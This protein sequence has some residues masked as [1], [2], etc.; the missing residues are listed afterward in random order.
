MLNTEQA[1]AQEAKKKNQR[2]A[3]L[4]AK[5][6][7][8]LVPA[9]VRKQKRAAAYA[10]ANARANMVDGLFGFKIL[11]DELYNPQTGVSTKRPGADRDWFAFANGF[12]SSSRL[13][14]HVQLKESLAVTWGQKATVRV[15]DADAHGLNNPM[16]ALPTLWRAIQALHLGRE[17]LLP[18]L[19]NG[20]VPDGIL[21][22]G[23][24][25]TS[26]NGLHYIERT[27]TPVDG[28]CLDA[29]L[30]RIHECF[31]LYNVTI[32]PGM[33]EVLPSTNGQSRLP[34]GPGCE[35]VY[36]SE[37]AVSFQAGAVILGSLERVS[38]VFPD[39]V[40]ARTCLVPTSYEGEKVLCSESAQAVE[41]E[42][43]AAERGSYDVDEE[44]MQQAYEEY[45]AMPPSPVYSI[46]PAN[47]KFADAK[48]LHRQVSKSVSSPTNLVPTFYE[49]RKVLGSGETQTEF[50]ERMERL[51][52]DGAGAG[53]R[54][55]EFW[56]LCFYIRL[57]RG[58]TNEQTE[59]RILSWIEKAPHASADLSNLNTTK[60]KAAHRLLRGHIRRIEAGLASGKFFQAGDGADRARSSSK[61]G[62][63]L[64]LCVTSTEQ[65]YEFRQ[66]G[67]DFL[68][69]AF[70][71][72]L[73]VTMPEWVKDRLPVLV[74]AIAHYS[75]NGT[76]AL[77]TWTV[78][79]YAC[80][81]MSK[82]DP[83]DG[84]KRPAYKI[85]IN[86]LERF[87]VVSGIIRKANK[88]QRLAAVY[89]TN[90]VQHESAKDNGGD[91]TASQNDPDCRDQSDASKPDADLPGQDGAGDVRA[92]GES[93]PR[94]SGE[95]CR[96][97]VLGRGQRGR[98]WLSS[99]REAA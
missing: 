39:V 36:P 44:A 84:V 28:D 66:T 18:E 56:D 20:R 50:V 61:V 63:A 7:A 71:E 75:R 96:D 19:V 80:S 99:V 89:E 57:T 42:P 86:L 47:P 25:V 45:A 5:E 98:A 90:T 62:D 73:L 49:G 4:R 6:R 68:Q 87:G 78:K 85:L 24:I 58:Y 95:P 65:E 94:S 33:L 54:N 15:I 3:R 29:D 2:A 83:T 64:L 52:V 74:G 81:R 97:G 22:D 55:E 10:R 43:C 13:L 35:F 69:D 17:V 9:D 93:E 53:Q 46:K 40:K 12:V 60:R 21:L 72:S 37:G 34:L 70:G 88:L 82:A 31:R 23:I 41:P 77:P 59:Q 76:I 51:L 91:A 26:P 27:A 48:K 16:A 92:S 32:R 8:K 1:D 79:E 30:A 38:R 67:L 14:R 11:V